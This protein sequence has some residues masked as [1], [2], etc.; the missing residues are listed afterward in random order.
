MN[1]SGL[2][3][4]VPCRGGRGRVT[5]GVGAAKRSLGLAPLEIFGDAQLA[6]G[7]GAE[8]ADARS[9][10]TTWSFEF[11]DSRTGSGGYYVQVR[12]RDTAGNVGTVTGVRFDV[13]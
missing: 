8:V 6:I 5:A 12:A 2:P 1:L 7:D 9:K 10:G 3:R 4:P 11:D 13:R